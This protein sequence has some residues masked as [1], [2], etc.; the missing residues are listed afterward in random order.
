MF[1]LNRIAAVGVAAMLAA[2]IA[3]AQAVP[4]I[5]ASPESAPKDLAK[6]SSVTRPPVPVSSN[7]ASGSAGAGAAASAPA[8]G[9]R[10]ASPSAG[11]DGEQHGLAQTKV[12]FVDEIAVRSAKDEHRVRGRF[13]DVVRVS[14]P[15]LRE[16]V[17]IHG[18]VSYQNVPGETKRRGVVTWT[19]V[20]REDIGRR[21]ALGKPLQSMFST[22]AKTVVPAGQMITAQ[23]DVDAALAAA[24]ALFPVESQTTAEEKKEAAAD[25]QKNESKAARQGGTSEGRQPSSAAGGMPENGML[26]MAPGPSTPGSSGEPLKT[27]TPDTFDETTVGCSPR[28]DLEQDVAI[29][30]ARLTR[31]GKPEGVCED[32]LTRYALMRDYS[33]CPPEIGDGAVVLA[34]KL[35]YLG[36]HGRADVRDCAPDPAQSRTLERIYGVCADTVAESMPFKQFRLSYLDGAGQQKYATECEIDTNAPLPVEKDYAS[37]QPVIDAQAGAM[38][39][40][41][42]RFFIDNTGAKRTLGECE[43]EGDPIQLQKSYDGC[44]EDVAGEGGSVRRKFRWSYVDRQGAP[45]TAGACQTDTAAEGIVPV[46]TDYTACDPVVDG[47]GGTVTRQGQRY[48]IDSTGQRRNIGSC[49]PEPTGAQALHKSFAGCGE[50]VSDDGATVRRKHR[51]SYVDASNAVKSIGE[52]RTGTAPDDIIAARKS[53]EGCGE[54]VAADGKTVRRK[55]RYAYIG[56]NSETKIVGSC[57]PDASPEGVVT[58]QTDLTSCA[59]VI[60]GDGGTMRRQGQRFYLDEAGQRRNIGACQPEGEIVQLQKSYDGCGEEVAADGTTRRKHRYSYVDAARQVQT[61][62][63]CR[64]DSAADGL[65]TVQVDFGA[66]D[67]VVDGTA[68]T[69][70]RQGQRYYVDGAGLKKI[71]GAC[72]PQG[73]PAAMTKAFAGCGEEVAAD[74]A[75][76]RR[77]HRYTYVDRLGAAKTA[78]DCRVDASPEGLVTV[79][80]DLAS[81][82]PVIDGT[83]GTMRRQGQRYYVDETGQRRDLGACQPEGETVQLAKSYD[84][85]GE[86]VAADGTTRRKH[87]YSYVDA[88]NAV[89]TI[90]EC[91]VDAAP[92][93]MLTVQVDFGACDPVVDGTTGTMR[94]QGQRYYVDGAG[95]K[96]IIGACEP[97][98]EPAAMTKA[99]AGCGEEVAA[100]GATVRRKHR[101]T[102]VDRLGAAKTAGD[103]RTDTSPEGLVTVQVDF[104]ACDPVVDGAAGTMRRQ[105]QRFYVDGAAQKK[106]IGGCEPQGEPAAMTKAYAGCGEEVAADGKTVR[107]KHRYTYVDRLGA[108]KTA[109]DCRVD[110]SP[111]GLVTVQSDLASCAPVIDGTA[112]TM[113]RQGQRFYLDEAGVKKPLGAC[114]PQGELVQLAKSYTGCGEDVAADGTTV[115]RKHRFSYVDAANAVKTVG[116]CRIDPAPEGLVTIQVDVTSCTPVIDGVAGTMRRQAQRYYLDEAGTRKTLGACQPDGESVQL[117]KSYTGCGEEVAADGKTVRRKYRFSYVDTAN[118]AQTVG[119]CRVD[120]APE[121]LLTVQDDYDECSPAVDATTGTM[122]RQA[123]RYYVD[124]T[125]TRKMLGVCEPRGEQIVLQKS[126]TGCAEE[127]AADG[128]VRRMHRFSY[129]DAAKATQ[130]VGTCTVDTTAEGLVPVLKDYDQCNPAIDGNVGTMRRQAIGYYISAAGVKK[131]VGACAPEGDPIQLQKAYDGC[132]EEVNA[133]AHSVR[134]KFKYTYIDRNNAA[135]AVGTCQVDT[136]PEG[137]IPLAKDFSTCE[138][139]IDHTAGRATPAYKLSYTSGAGAQQTLGS[140]T[141]DTGQV[142]Q[143]ARDYGKCDA[144]VDITTNKVRPNYQRYFLGL[145]GSPKLVGGCVADTEQQVDL[146]RSYAGCTDAVDVVNRTARPQYKRYFTLRNGSTQF[147]DAE[148]QTEAETN[149]PVTEDTAACTPEVDLP[150]AKIYARAELVYTDR[151]NRRVLVR[152]C[153]RTVD[154]VETALPITRTEEGCSLR[155]D[156]A[157]RKSYERKKSTYTVGADITMVQDCTETSITFAHEDVRGVC[158]DLVDHASGLAQPQNRWR[159]TLAD[160]SKEYVSECQPV[161]TESR[162]FT[163]TTDGCDGLYYHYETAGQSYGASRWFYTQFGGASRVYV[164]ECQEDRTRTFAHESRIN[165]YEHDDAVKSS[166]AKTEVYITTPTGELT[167]SAPRLREGTAAVPYT[168]LSSVT[169]ATGTVVY[170]DCNAFAEMAVYDQYQRA[171]NTTIEMNAGPAAAQGPRNACSYV[172]TWPLASSGSVYTDVYADPGRLITY[173]RVC[174]FSAQRSATREDGA[175]FIVATTEA[176]PNYVDTKIGAC[177]GTAYTGRYGLCQSPAVA[178][179]LAP[180]CPAA[181]DPVQALGW[182]ALMGWN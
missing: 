114:E 170:E 18:T 76:V 24:R 27:V 118:A 79:Q 158:Q 162:N 176:P 56:E 106:I 148:C 80:T 78:G 136:S 129:V 17:V 51:Y 179:W 105:G 4:D 143:L 10:S 75:T 175:N 137:L 135:Q 60:D 91:R 181:A 155:H 1:R 110:T 86:E 97:Q 131:T 163:K 99:Y 21:Q 127:V 49:Y 5:M 82:A 156:F 173:Y 166:R 150:G 94:R 35:Y 160:G 36:E 23:G 178:P 12:A 87:R 48:Y 157:A 167:V 67:P 54:E 50:E 132:G 19:S 31:N 52:C 104:G 20:A 53:Y 92:E 90:G 55:H 107:R 182:N 83:A 174:T 113:R 122:R 64:V 109:G 100:D 37:C 165:G 70:R 121:G 68:G 139:V 39:R 8:A 108:A 153:Q 69:M 126:Y 72:E 146:L 59:P 42:Q 171:D 168:K 34:Y 119:E 134:R 40:T 33:A 7:A 13:A 25:K 164:T 96:K 63:E 140:C 112:G 177:E 98:G 77:K 101:Y 71:I 115:R 123:Q 45:Q 44:G 26:K 117:Q 30:Q 58:V 41:G 2:G 147:V 120:T 161:T 74:G 61:I 14:D 124:H 11:S 9:A 152:S 89:K 43:P 141:P 15:R 88:A 32:T 93:G 130:T 47:Q 128:S 149:F 84:G 102:Y 172:N 125:G 95:L 85:C 62:G 169:K 46:L 138:P 65:L 180:A 38:R 29:G 116:E 159:I 142:V 28:V 3:H 151:N 57:R 22:D 145:D 16:Q 154:A 81:C 6:P 103:C 66:C 144:T 73:E 111:E 133:A